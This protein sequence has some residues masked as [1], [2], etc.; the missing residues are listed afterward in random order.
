MDLTHVRRLIDLLAH[1]PVTELEVEE[2]GCRIR[3][4][5]GDRAQAAP[6][7]ASVVS[8]APG[9]D[10]APASAAAD[11]APS[12]P[13]E[14]VIAAPSYG[15]FHLSPSPG[16]PPFVTVGQAVQAGQEVGL[17]EAM[18]VFN[19]VRATQAG[20]IAAVLVEDGTEVEAGTPLFR[21]A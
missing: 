17:V 15:V 8:S 3:I 20:D 1:A 18:K 13:A 5:R 12:P 4:T 16:A 19:A 21:L 11:T 7:A 9:M 2:G 10:T 14:V 6:A